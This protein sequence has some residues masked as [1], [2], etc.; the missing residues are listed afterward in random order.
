MRCWRWLFGNK[1]PLFLREGEEDLNEGGDDPDPDEYGVAEDPLQAVDFV[2]QPPRVQLKG[3]G[4]SDSR[5]KQGGG[6]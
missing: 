2:V 5:A 4:V 1:I 6:G 3:G